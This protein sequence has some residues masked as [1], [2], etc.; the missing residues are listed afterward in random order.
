M[1][2]RGTTLPLTEE[3]RTVLAGIRAYWHEHGIPPTI[4]DL[5]DLSGDR[6]PSVIYHH[7][8]RLERLG[9]IEREPG[10]ARSIRLTARQP[11]RPHNAIP[12]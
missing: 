2:K 8:D 6:S 12:T 11:E 1:P 3:N 4:R 5:C 10:V 9:L 7:L